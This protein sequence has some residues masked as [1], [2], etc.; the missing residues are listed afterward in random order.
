MAGVA[1][2]SDSLNHHALLYRDRREYL[3]CIAACA[4]AC[5]GN[6]EP[7]FIALP[8]HR[9][10]LVRAALDS[11]AGHRLAYADMAEIGRNPARM[12]PEFGAFIERHRGQRVCLIQEP[13]WP[14]RSAE[15]LCEATRHEAL[16]DVAFAE[17]AATIMCLYDAGLGRSVISG[18]GRTHA[19]IQR[20]GTLENSSGYAGAGGLPAE[21]E[22]PLAA[23]PGNA[24]VLPYL[25]ELRTL[26]KL[27]ADYA[28]GCGLSD[29]H[30]ANLVLAVS[31]V[32]GNTLRHTDGGGTLRIWRTGSEILCQVD[33]QGRIADPLAGRRRRSP[34]DS[35]HGLWVVNQICDLVELRTGQEGT[36]IRLHMRLPAR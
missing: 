6:A 16:I 26:R 28:T 31:E 14:G 8:G 2:A 11:E 3:A 4:R 23:P 10:G 36:T 19:A 12:I 33:D 35:G 13:V 29:D 17:A 1:T 9:G 27:V 7:V 20:G 25:T 32:A 21:C 18:A 34:G 22:L 24:I 5:L 30:T 15:E